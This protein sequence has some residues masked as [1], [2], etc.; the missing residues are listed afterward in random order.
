MFTIEVRVERGKY[1]MILLHVTVKVCQP[2]WIPS[3]NVILEVDST[4]K[5]QQA[6]PN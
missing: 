4:Q 2:V 5:N 1:T 6:L 3:G